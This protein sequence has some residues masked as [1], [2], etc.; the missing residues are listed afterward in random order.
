MS[1]RCLI[2]D[3]LPIKIFQ[4]PMTYGLGR[5]NVQDKVGGNELSLK[6]QNTNLSKE[7]SLYFVCEVF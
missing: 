4:Y 6:L 1:A 5:H 2:K 3:L 7:I